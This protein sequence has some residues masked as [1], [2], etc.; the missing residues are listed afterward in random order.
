MKASL[1]RCYR[2]E[3][4]PSTDSMRMS[5]SVLTPFI[6]AHRYLGAKNRCSRVCD[7]FIPQHRHVPLLCFSAKQT[8]SPGRSAAR[9]CVLLCWW[10]T[11]LRLKQIIAGS[12]HSRNHRAPV[13]VEC[14]CVWCRYRER[15]GAGFGITFP[16]PRKGM[17]PNT[18]IHRMRLSDE[19]VGTAAR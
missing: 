18:I 12:I 7:I 15:V 4:I 17:N 19:P 6:R 9:V 13:C 10:W 2:T 5:A 1:Q 11:L 14:I 3:D 16:N 8:M